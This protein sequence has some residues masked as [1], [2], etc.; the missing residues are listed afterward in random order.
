M[1]PSGGPGLRSFS[2]HEQ[3]M[4]QHETNMV[5]HN[6]QPTRDFAEA[7]NTMTLADS[8]ASSHLAASLGNLHS[9]NILNTVE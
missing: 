3:H 6:Y 8:G 2:P 7:S 9:V 1:Y 5:D 4:Q